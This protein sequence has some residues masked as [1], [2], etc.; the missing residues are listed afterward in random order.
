MIFQTKFAQKGLL[1]KKCPYS[2]LFWSAFSR[3]RTEYRE[4]LSISPY[5]VQMQE[6]A[7]QSNSKYGHFLCSA[8]ISLIFFSI[9]SGEIFDF[10]IVAYCL[11]SKTIVVE[12]CNLSFQLETKKNIFPEHTFFG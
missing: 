9:I 1:H 5:S 6:N 2:E 4:K 12:L 3:I 7:D 8:T 11:V 10:F